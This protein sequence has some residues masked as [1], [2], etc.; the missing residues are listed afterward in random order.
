MSDV[1]ETQPQKHG[2][3][4]RVFVETRRQELERELAGGKSS[5]DRIADLEAAL[6]ALKA[7]LTGD[8]D[9]IPPVVAQDLAKWIDTSKYLGKTG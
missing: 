4:L 3:G 6:A 1:T 8:L 5:P 9:Q 7:L 2:Q